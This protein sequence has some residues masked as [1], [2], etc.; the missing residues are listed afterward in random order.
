MMIIAVLIDRN[1]AFPAIGDHLAAVFNVLLNK[2]C[3]G[4]RG[5]VINKLKA[6]TADFAAFSLH[7]RNN[8]AL[9][10]GTAAS[11]AR[12]LAANEKFINFNFTR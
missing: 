6:N 11:F 2:W 5:A 12:F 7:R 1:I 4:S 3:Q 10:V 9:A 8:N